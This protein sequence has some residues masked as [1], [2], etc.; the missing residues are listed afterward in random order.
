MKKH[1][2]KISGLVGAGILILCFQN[3]SDMVVQDEV[4]YQSSL[5]EYQKDL[6]QKNLPSIL[7]SSGLAYWSKPGAPSYVDIVTSPNLF[8][9]DKWSVVIAADRSAPNGTLFGFNSG[10]NSEEGRI[11]IVGGKL[12]A[13]HFSDASN[14]SYVETNL[15]TTGTKMVI[16]AAFGAEPTQITLLVNGVIQTAAIAKTGVPGTFSL[17]AKSVGTVSNS[18]IES[19]VHGA[20][21]TGVTLNAG[22]LNVMSRYIATENSIPN[23]IY[24]PTL[25]GSGDG[26]NTTVTDPLLVAAKA[27]IDAKC[28]SCHNSTGSGGNLTG[29]TSAKA[30]AGG[31]VVA[32]RPDQSKLYF[33]LKG[34][35]SGPS[36]KRDMPA[37]GGS[38]SAAEV[39]AVADWISAIK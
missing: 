34:S 28:I 18:V 26:S 12:R 22:Q 9:A 7:S 39:K 23:V 29:L 16:A 1:L 3:C 4:I 14:Y 35:L 10:M 20:P 30:V 33:R 32:G 36:D 37:G 15:P 17:L 21:D 2:F 13:Y 25:M 6:D 11:S 27:V 8:L 31:W 24:D 19:F 38:I 5:A